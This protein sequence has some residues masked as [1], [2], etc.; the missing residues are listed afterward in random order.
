MVLIYYYTVIFHGP[1]AL[2]SPREQN[3]GKTLNKKETRC[4]VRSLCNVM[5]C[6]TFEVLII[7]APYGNLFKWGTENIRTQYSPCRW[8]HLSFNAPKDTFKF[9]IFHAIGT[10]LSIH[11]EIT[12]MNKS[13]YLECLAVEW[14]YSTTSVSWFLYRL[15]NYIVVY[16]DSYAPSIT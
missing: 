6:D 1:P 12:T 3:E 15:T 5:C 13:I 10:I 7:I 8:L 9:D 2:V 14:H 11:D 4:V 16:L